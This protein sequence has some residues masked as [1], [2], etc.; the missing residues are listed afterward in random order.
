[1]KILVLDDNEQGDTCWRP[2]SRPMG[3]RLRWAENG[4]GALE[5]R[6]DGAFDLII[7]DTLMPVMDGFELCRK[8]EKA[9]N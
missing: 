2:F 3:M 8:L 4:Q 5:R 7:R 9:R 1:M 6:R